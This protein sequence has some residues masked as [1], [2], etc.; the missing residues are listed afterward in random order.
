MNG[1]D[2]SGGDQKMTNDEPRSRFEEEFER[3]WKE[4]RRTRRLLNI[5]LAALAALGIA[6]VLWCAR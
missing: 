3:A 6:A 1:I 2:R 4:A 5:A